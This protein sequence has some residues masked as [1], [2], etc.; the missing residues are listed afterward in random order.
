[1]ALCFIRLLSGNLLWLKYHIDKI[2][3]SLPFLCVCLFLTSLIFISVQ[4]FLSSCTLDSLIIS[5]IKFDF[6]S[7][8]NVSLKVWG[9]FCYWFDSNIVG[10]KWFNI[11]SKCLLIFWVCWFDLVINMW[12]L[13]S[14]PHAT[15]IAY[16]NLVN[17]PYF[18]LVLLANLSDI[19]KPVYVRSRILGIFYPFSPLSSSQNGIPLGALDDCWENQLYLILM[20]FKLSRNLDV[21]AIHRN[22]IPLWSDFLVHAVRNL[23]T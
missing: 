14:M 8:K 6:Y 4:W 3:L 2:F 15:T 10:Q 18:C 12:G 5:R 9:P 11:T 13:L 19:L 22:I 21:C 20:C 17:K 23:S 7:C 16:E 1:M